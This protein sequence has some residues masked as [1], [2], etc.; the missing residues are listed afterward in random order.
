MSE[1]TRSVDGFRPFAVTFTGA[2]CRHPPIFRCSGELP[3]PDT[4]MS[5]DPF[6]DDAEDLVLARRAHAGDGQAA[7]D[8]F[9]RYRSRLLRMV[10]LRLD[11]RLR[12]RLDA[13]DIVQEAMLDAVRRLP[14]YLAD[15]KMEFFLWLRW[16][17]G[18]RLLDAHRRNL[19]AQKRDAGQE[20]SLH[21]RAAPEA[22]SLVLAE[23]LMG[24]LTSP[25]HAVRRGEIKRTVQ[26]AL[27]SL[28]P[29]DREVLVLRH[30]E[31][32]SNLQTAQ[33]LG[34]KKSGASK[35]YVAAVRRIRQCL[36]DVVKL[37]DLL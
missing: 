14:E 19:G 20:V 31:H 26:E 27:N 13:G 36:A 5:N 37:E 24:R 16:I 30:F 35:R 3:G 12:A 18:D 11:P 17:T 34:L 2:V 15:P 23:Q 8:L 32:L 33:V 9:E 7:F 25:S 22:T 21:Q 29:I 10:D 6:P 1:F 4:D 28:E